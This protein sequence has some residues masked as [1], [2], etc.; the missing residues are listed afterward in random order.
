MK[1]VNS[2]L[3]QGMMQVSFLA[4]VKNQKSPMILELKSSMFTYIHFLRIGLQVQFG[5]GL[6]PLKFS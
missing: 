2:L 6:C 5:P 3:K 1:F 4:L